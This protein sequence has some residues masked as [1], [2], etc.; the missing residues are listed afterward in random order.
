MFKIKEKNIPLILVNARTQRR[1]ATIIGRKSNA[2]PDKTIHEKSNESGSESYGDVD[3]G[4]N[5]DNQ[6][7]EGADQDAALPINDMMGTSIQS[8]WK[9]KLS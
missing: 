8:G 1:N 4:N 2:A 5:V 3:D 9:L 6:A 7:G